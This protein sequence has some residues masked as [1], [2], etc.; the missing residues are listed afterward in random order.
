MKSNEVECPYCGEVVAINHDDGAGYDETEIHRQ[1]CKHCL[2]IFTFTTA[3]FFHYYPER[4]DCLNGADHHYEK[5][6]THPEQLARMR[7][8]AC[9]DEKPLWEQQPA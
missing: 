6:K 2:K 7:C 3:I 4:A 1:E 8:M 9:G 5:T